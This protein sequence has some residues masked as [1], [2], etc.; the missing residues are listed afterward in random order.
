MKKVVVS[1]II[2]GFVVLVH[3]KVI[4]A[5]ETTLGATIEGGSLILSNSTATNVSFESRGI[6]AIEQTTT[7]SIGDTDNTNTAGI[8]VQDLRGTGLGWAATMTTTNL[9]TQGAVKTLAGSNNT[10]GFTGTYTGVDA[11]YN[12]YGLYTIEITTG[13]VVGSAI[14]KW[15]DP[16]GNVTIGTTT[17]S[18]AALNNGLSVVFDIATYVVGD[19]WSIAVDALRYN[20]DTSKGLT[21]T[22]SSI[23]V[24][25][26]SGTGVTAGEGGL[27]QGT[28][29]TSDPMTIMTA[30][31]DQGMGDYFID[32]GLSQTIHPNAYAGS[33]SAIVTLTVS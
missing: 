5:V 4:R 30:A 11:I 25:S 12:S 32:L 16:A 26:G 14:F 23:N 28:S 29:A 6:S 9:V 27:M 2:L 19:K 3:G 22:P 1:I 13:G 21:V 7:A 20:Y 24:V 10:V 8:E 33:Y 18:S 17:S 15:T 31:G